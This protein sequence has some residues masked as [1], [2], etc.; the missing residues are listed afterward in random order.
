MKAEGQRKKFNSLQNDLNSANTEAEIVSAIEGQKVVW[1]LE[2]REKIEAM[3]AE[4]DRQIAQLQAQNESLRHQLMGSEGPPPFMEDDGPPPFSDFDNF[5]CLGLLNDSYI[6]S[7]TLSTNGVSSI[8]ANTV[9][10]D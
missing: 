6:M 5:F 8:D 1:E 2:M 4:S 9:F 7:L 3:K 10:C